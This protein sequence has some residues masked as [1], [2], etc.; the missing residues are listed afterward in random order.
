MFLQKELII[1]IDAL[2]KKLNLKRTDLAIM[3]GES[4]Y[5]ISYLMSRSCTLTS[6]RLETYKLLPDFLESILVKHGSFTKL[7]VESARDSIKRRKI[8][9]KKLNSEFEKFIKDNKKCSQDS[10]KMI[11][12]DL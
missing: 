10:Y 5:F 11:D 9:A 3:L 2:L 4:K 7:V 6:E 1:K 12:L 8:Y